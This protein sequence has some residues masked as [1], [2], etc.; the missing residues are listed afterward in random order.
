MSFDVSNDSYINSKSNYFGGDQKSSN[1]E[2]VGV[3]VTHLKAPFLLQARWFYSDQEQ[4]SYYDVPELSGEISRP[5][6][7]IWI[8]RHREAWSHA[9]SFWQFGYWQPRFN[10]DGFRPTEDGLTGLFYKPS[11]GSRLKMTAFVSPFYFPETDPT[12]YEKNNMLVSQNPWFR[13]TPPVVSLWEQLTPVH[14]NVNLPSLT[15][16]VLKPSVAYKLDYK[17][18]PSATLHIAYAYKPMNTPVLGFNFGIAA[19]S[20]GTYMGVNVEP[21]F[22]YHH[23][24][25]VENIWRINTGAVGHVTIIPSVTYDSPQLAS[26]PYQ[27]IEQNLAPSWMGSLTANWDVYGDSTDTI[28]GGIMNVWGNQPEDLGEEAQPESQFALRPRYLSAL[29]LGFSF[30]PEKWGEHL[31]RYETEATFDPRLDGWELLNEY[32]FSFDRSWQARVRADL[33]GLFADPNP[34][35]E[36]GFFALYRSNSLASV[37]VAYVF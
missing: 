24:A 31:S 19:D 27:W 35:Q 7:K 11:T 26:V 18:S 37:D 14:M 33:L 2:T 4:T 16:I 20:S 22:D 30:S 29:R 6:Y 13:N 36:N 8:G 17:E 21:Q 34:S 23:I 9:D 10:W 15:S 12:Y 25:T 5:G 28:Y 1:I 32:L 3:G